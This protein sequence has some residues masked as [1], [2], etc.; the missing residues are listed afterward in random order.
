M[1]KEVA[2]AGYS[3]DEGYTPFENLH[4]VLQEAKYDGLMYPLELIG[5]IPFLKPL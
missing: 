3:K 2:I 5:N 1:Y 4:A